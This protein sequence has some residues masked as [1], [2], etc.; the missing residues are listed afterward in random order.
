MTRMGSVIQSEHWWREL[1]TWKLL[2]MHG[3]PV[4]IRTYPRDR[5]DDPRACA[6]CTQP[7]RFEIVEIRQTP[8]AIH[9]LSPTKWHWCGYCDI[10]G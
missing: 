7:A 2:D 5:Y 8:E 3:R 10:G 9:H 1:E 4:C 6:D